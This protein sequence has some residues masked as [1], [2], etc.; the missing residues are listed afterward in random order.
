VAAVN[1]PSRQVGGD[2]YDLVPLAGGGLAVAV[3]DVSGKGVP[4][5]LLMSMLHAALHVQ[6]NGDLRASALMGRLNRILFDSTSPDQ[7]ATF[8]FGVYDRRGRR[9]RFTNGGHNFPLLIRTGGDVETLG[10]G[11]LVLGFVPD[12][13]YEEG[14][15]ALGP[16]DLLVCFSDGVTEECREGDDDDL[17][18]EERL[19]DT[20]LRH[21]DEPAARIVEAI[22]DEVRRFCGRDQF[23]DDFTLIVLRGAEGET[24]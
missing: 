19:R 3:G 13:P 4:A 23:A 11:G 5:A 8:F 1:V 2:Y 12:V 20:V 14:E 10:T 17:F 7:F 18:G 6:M 16:G 24:P 21:R 9:F 15:T 22:Q